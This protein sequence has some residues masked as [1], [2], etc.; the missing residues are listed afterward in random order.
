MANKQENFN[1]SIYEIM[2]LGCL[3]IVGINIQ[4]ILSFGEL[5]GQFFDEY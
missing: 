3:L 2:E 4:A 1:L 5:V